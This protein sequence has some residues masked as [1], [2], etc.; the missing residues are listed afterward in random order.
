MDTPGKSACEAGEGELTCSEDK[1]VVAETAASGATE[2][3]SQQEPQ[4]TDK[5]VSAG[6]QDP[7]NVCPKVPSQTSHTSLTP[8]PLEQGERNLGNLTIVPTVEDNPEKQSAVGLPDLLTESFESELKNSELSASGEDHERNSSE[9]VEQLSVKL[10]KDDSK[11]EDCSGVCG[12]ISQGESVLPSMGILPEA[13]EIPTQASQPQRSQPTV[14]SAVTAAPGSEKRSPEPHPV[15]PSDVVHKIKKIKW[16]DIEVP[17]ITQNNNGP[18]PLLAIVNVM[19]LKGQITLPADRSEITGGELVLVVGNAL[20]DQPR[21]S[22]PSEMRRHVEKNTEDAISI[23]HKLLTGLDVN[24]KFSGVRDFEFTGEL[25]VFDLLGIMLYHGWVVDPSSEA[26]AIIKDLSY[27]Q[28]TNNIFAWREEAIKNNNN[29]LL[30]KAM[31]CEEFMTNSGSQL[32]IHGL[33]ELGSS[34]VREEIAVLFRNNHFSTIYKKGDQ[35]YQLLTDQGFLHE[36]MVWETLNDVDATF[37]EFV[38]GNF[39]PIPPAPEPSSSSAS[40]TQNMTMQQQISSD[41]EIAKKLQEEENRIAA[42][43]EAEA[44]APPQTTAVP[45]PETQ[46]PPQQPPHTHEEK[47]KKDCVIL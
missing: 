25:C 29:D 37:S 32:T 39:E 10:D 43:A 18:C 17:I 46:S 34:L 47:K 6:T 44:N 14:S 11:P 1:P 3:D 9:L 20:F 28:L 31:L 8:S 21:N 40:S 16:Q 5:P 23:L 33:F 24:V 35:L 30:V 12:W 15:D 13:E 38:N 22:L 7:E 19:I 36:N 27:N 2:K 4:N 26:A 41:E 45:P 42:E